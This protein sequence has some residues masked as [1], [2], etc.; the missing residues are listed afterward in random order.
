MLLSR[1]MRNLRERDWFSVGVELFVLVLGI[2]LGLQASDW[3]NDRRDRAEEHDY[4]RRLLE[5]N[6]ANQAIVERG[7]ERNRH[8]AG[9]ARSISEALA[10]A[11]RQ[12]DQQAMTTAL[13]KWFVQPVLHLQRSTYAEMISSGKLLL[14]RDQRLRAQLAEEDATHAEVHRLDVLIPPMEH[15]AMPLERH[16]RWYIDNAKEDADLD[17]KSAACTFDVDGMRHDPQVQSALAQ[18]Y[19]Y[20]VLFA[21]FHERELKALGSTR[22]LLQAALDQA[23]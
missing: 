11:D 19:R 8:T 21:M 12:P 7:L 16:T 9:L 13:C 3:A 22:D 4:L 5:D 23:H 17:P 14:L 6:A 18:V 20:E 10:S 2:V 15:A 1:V